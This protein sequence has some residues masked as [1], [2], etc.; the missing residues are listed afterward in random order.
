MCPILG[1]KS[2]CKFLYLLESCYFGR[3]VRVPH[4]MGRHT[5][6]ENEHSKCIVKLPH[7]EP[8]AAWLWIHE[9]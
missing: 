4:C 9:Y 7:A 1:A 3:V 5:Q 8:H 6:A 2:E